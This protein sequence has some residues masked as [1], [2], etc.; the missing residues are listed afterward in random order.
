MR[1]YS[2]FIFFVVC[3][4]VA[5][6]GVAVEA[7]RSWAAPDHTRLVFDTS[8]PVPHKIFSLEKPNRLVIDL[9]NTRLRSL[10]PKPKTED[11]II[12]SIRSAPRN[13]S[14]LR[15]V[16][17]LKDRVRPKSFL[18][19]PNREYGHRLVVDLEVRDF[20]GGSK[21]SGV[22]GENRAEARPRDIV[23]AI[24]AGHGGEDPGAK[25]RRGTYEKDVVLAIAKKLAVLVEAEPGMR[26]VLIR[27]G[28]YF[29]PLRERMQKARKARADLFISIHA[30]AFRD[31][32]VRGSSVFTLSQRGASSEA[33][34]WLAERE[35]TADLIGGVKLEN[36]DGLLASVLLDLSQTAT[37]QASTGAARKVFNSLRKLG[38]THSDRV[39][40]AGFV[41]LKSPDVPSMLVETAFISNPRE[42]RR[43]KDAG[44]QRKLAMALRDGIRGY[45][46]TNPPHGVV[47]AEVRPHEHV[48]A[49][50]DTLSDIAHQYQISLNRL[51][52]VNQLASDRIRIGQKLRIPEG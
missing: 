20:P 47:S 32:R 29:L 28:D 33:A 38:K 2:T 52:K 34:R 3:M 31:R 8:G 7:V 35:N 22:S 11:R 15:V 50:G 9:K 44:H 30:D 4:P 1:F 16:L 37:L 13:G 36:K 45:F 40:Q 42:E 14:D 6:G 48:I 39:Q 49:R 21:N 23:I 12:R 24:D 18:L 26:A 46:Q 17:D 19:K 10:L 41:V 51:R 27:D 5:A 43:L 25:G